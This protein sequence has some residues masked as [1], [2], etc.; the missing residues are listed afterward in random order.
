MKRNNLPFSLTS[1]GEIVFYERNSGN[2]IQEYEGF[3]HMN[4]RK[5]KIMRTW[6]DDSG[7][8]NFVGN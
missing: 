5:D 4:G 8:R 3:Y 2:Q 1:D 7:E 6:I